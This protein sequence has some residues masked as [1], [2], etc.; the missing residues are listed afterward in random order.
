MEC[1]NCNHK[2]KTFKVEI[3]GLN[4]GAFSYQAECPKCGSLMVNASPGEYIE[5]MS[6][7]SNTSQLKNAIGGFIIQVTQME[8]S[9]IQAESDVLAL[10]NLTT[11]DYGMRH[12]II[13][14]CRKS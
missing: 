6:L 2:G 10:A 7:V 5:D 4:M 9:V 8:N 3:K 12:Y 11:R 14:T 1:V 13:P